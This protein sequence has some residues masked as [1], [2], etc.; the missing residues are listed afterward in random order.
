MGELRENYSTLG[1][2]GFD[3]E[4]PWSYVIALSAYGT[5][6]QEMASWWQNMAVIP[7]SKAPSASG[8][9]KIID[10]VEGVLPAN[11]GGRG[12]G[13]AALRDRSRS[14][15]KRQ[16]Q[17]QPQQQQISK[18]PC[19]Y[20]NNRMG[21]CAGRGPCADGLTHGV[22]DVCHRSGHRSCDVHKGKGKGKKGDKG[23][24]KK[25]DKGKGKDKEWR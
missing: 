21:R 16:Q 15:L 3:E 1:P 23:K 5:P 19:W 25:G 8:A 11:L 18:T 14:P 24:G 13:P 12:S 20:W 2:E 9:R 10:D 6:D 7:C 22:C 17:Q 4:R